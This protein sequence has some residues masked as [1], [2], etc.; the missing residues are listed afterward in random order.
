MAGRRLGRRRKKLPRARHSLQRRRHAQDFAQ[1]GRKK[2]RHHKAI[3]AIAI[4][5]RSPKYDGGIVTRL[6]SVVFGVVV[7]K[8]GLRF[9]DEGEEIWP[10]RYAIWAA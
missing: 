4:D 5:A 6:D 8:L 7:N 10:K 2:N 1:Q 9:Y 3:H